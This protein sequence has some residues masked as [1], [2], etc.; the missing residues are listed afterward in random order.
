LASGC[1]DRIRDPTTGLEDQI[2]ERTEQKGF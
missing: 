1:A 2:V